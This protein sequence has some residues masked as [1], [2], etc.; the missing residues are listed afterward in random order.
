MA[1]S[2]ARK[3]SESSE[4]YISRLFG[5]ARVRDGN[6]KPD[7]ISVNG[8]YNPR[9]SLELKTTSQSKCVVENYQLLYGYTTPGEYRRFL[10]LELAK[11]AGFLPGFAEE[12]PELFFGGER[13]IHYHNI[14]LRSD[15]TVLRELD[16]NPLA[17]LGLRYDSQYIVPHDFVFFSFA[18]GLHMR[19]K[20]P[21]A[22]CVDELKKL[23]RLDASEQHPRRFDSIKADINSFQ[24]L[25]LKDILYFFG[26]DDPR[27]T[28]KSRRR[29][30]LLRQIWPEVGQLRNLILPGPSQTRIHI[31]YRQEDEDLFA[32][33]VRARVEENN[34]PLTKI[35]EE[36]MQALLDPTPNPEAVERLLRW[37]D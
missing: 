32:R 14:M 1:I 36:R 30:A 23:V 37:K 35:V 29:V 2:G 10:G 27:P 34:P 15:R 20:K 21:I 11:E 16:H 5:L 26:E 7:L 25:N 17:E 31:L 13:T 19:T 8:D 22:E 6:R 18:I 24:N 12:N 4:T 9:W 33:Q 3:I 28:E